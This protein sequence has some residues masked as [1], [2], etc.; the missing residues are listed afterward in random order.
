MGRTRRKPHLTRTLFVVSRGYRLSDWFIPMRQ[1]NAAAHP[2][3]PVTAA[4]AEALAL[5]ISSWLIV[6]R[7]DG[8]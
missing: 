3:D 7:G 2:A 8:H 4:V 1:P 6:K 5:E